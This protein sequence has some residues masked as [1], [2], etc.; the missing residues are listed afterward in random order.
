VLVGE[1]GVGTDAA[2]VLTLVAD[3]LSAEGFVVALQLPEAAVGAAMDASALESV[4]STL[5][6]NAR[7]AGATRLDITLASRDG[8]VSIDLVDDGPGVPAADVDRIFDP[9]FT[10]KREQGGT[11]LGLAIARSLLG[12]YRGE[13]LLVPSVEGAHFRL[14]CPSSDAGTI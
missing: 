14:L 7:Q 9:F 4:L 10:S 8:T 12:A 2:A 5:C 6:E 3:A 1:R 11:G 13:L